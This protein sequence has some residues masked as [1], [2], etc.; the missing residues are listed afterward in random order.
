M[1]KNKTDIETAAREFFLV[2]S[3]HL[4]YDNELAKLAEVTGES[5]EAITAAADGELSNYPDFDKAEDSFVEW[6]LI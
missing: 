3:A 6:C 1:N 2:W 4:P 5:A